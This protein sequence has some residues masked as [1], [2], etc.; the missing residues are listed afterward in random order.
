MSMSKLAES[1]FG[2]ISRTKRNEKKL[3]ASSLGGNVSFL[4]QKE[5]KHYHPKSLLVIISAF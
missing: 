2:F 3:P 5:M 1:H 4:G